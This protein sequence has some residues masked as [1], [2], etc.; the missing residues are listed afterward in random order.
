MHLR[1]QR[2]S[3]KGTREAGAFGQKGKRRKKKTVCLD[4]RGLAYKKIEGA[5]K[6]HGSPYCSK[7]RVA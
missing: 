2:S 1:Q 6:V 3:E 5:M 7:E 4:K